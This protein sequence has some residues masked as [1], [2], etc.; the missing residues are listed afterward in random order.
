MGEK[1]IGDYFIFTVFVFLMKYCLYWECFMCGRWPVNAGWMDDWIGGYI[2]GLLSIF[3]TLEPILNVPVGEKDIFP[4]NIL[5]RGLSCWCHLDCQLFPWSR[6]FLWSHSQDVTKQKLFKLIQSM[7]GSIACIFF[8]MSILKN[9]PDW[10]QSH[11]RIRY[12]IIEA[13]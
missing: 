1:T 9:V 4:M 10:Q 13:G 2:A 8:T 6:F 5:L 3:F 7:P 12:A 11:K